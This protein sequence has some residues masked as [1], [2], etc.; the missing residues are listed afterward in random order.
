MRCGWQPE[1]SQREPV[2][3]EMDDSVQVAAWWAVGMAGLVSLISPAV[4]RPVL[5]RHGIIDRPNERSSH[6][7]PTLR[8]GGIAPL[9]GFVLACGLLAS[10]VDDQSR[11][12]IVM[13]GLGG[14]LAGLLGLA[15]D[16][17]GLSVLTR[18]AGHLL[19]GAL[20]STLLGVALG[21]HWWQIA[22]G[23]AVVMVYVNVANFMDG[24]NGI[25]GLHGLVVGVAYAVLGLLSHTAWLML[26]GLAV[27]VAF[28]VFL[29]WNLRSPGIFLGDVGSY[30][31]GASLASLGVAA[32]FA[33]FSPVAVLAPGAIY[34]ADTFSTIVR[35]LIREEPVLRS[36]RGHTYQRLTDTGLGHVPVAA[37]VTLFSLATSGLGVLVLR[38]WLASWLA[39]VLIAGVCALYLALPRIR[40]HR[41]APRAVNQLKPFE[42]PG[43]I[44]PRPGFAPTRWAVLGASGFVGSALV[45][46]LRSLGYE[47][48]E[49]PAPRLALEPASDDGNAVA[50]MASTHAETQVLSSA[51]H[52]VDVVVNAAGLATPDAPPSDLLYGANALLPALLITAAK[53]AGVRRAIHLSSAAVQGRREVLD[54]TA[55]VSPFSPYSR[56]KALGEWAFFA[57]AGPDPGTDAIVLRATSV[58]GPGRG[59]TAS[60]RRVANS[61]FASVAGAGTRPTVVSSINGLVDSISRASLS[62]QPLRRIVLQPW[63]GYSV[64]DVLRAAG[65]REPQHLPRLLCRT[66]LFCARSVGRVVPEVAG[67]ARRLELMWF[68]QR[69]DSAPGQGLPAVPR[70]VLESILSGREGHS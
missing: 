43:P 55:E 40:G 30:L 22:I 24:I 53:R 11:T 13:I 31:L 21:S 25:S 19:L 70:E 44:P 2:E 41:L 32:W 65:G 52:G 49:V 60:L 56:S 9:V 54:A 12:V 66:V 39:L 67:A 6:V 59:T 26:L 4:L 27:A 38:G 14:V 62:T 7:R 68:G 64:S 69:Q 50:S 8:A 57:A 34:L 35:R 36:H 17:Y 51:L 45:A 48:E 18:A 61:R 33:G 10:L 37:I 23:A 58:Q 16:V 20:V 5:Q 29:P 63:E 47:V 28:V 15:E 1:A 3:Q 42:L 46:H